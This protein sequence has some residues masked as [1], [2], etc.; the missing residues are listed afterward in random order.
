MILVAAS[1]VIPLVDDPLTVVARVQAAAGPHSIVHCLLLL[2]LMHDDLDVAD[3]HA[4]AIARVSLAI[5]TA[6]L[7]VL[8]TTWLI[9]RKAA[10][11]FATLDATFLLYAIDAF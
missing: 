7:V 3:L 5:L 8:A 10:R 1:L 6:I 9:F 4:R 2:L 11:S